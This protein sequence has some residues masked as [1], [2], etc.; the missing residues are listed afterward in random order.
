MR[1]S[2]VESGVRHQRARPAGVQ[3]YRVAVKFAARYREP[4]HWIERVM[5]NQTD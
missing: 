2:I 5:F 3:Q 4:S 1:S